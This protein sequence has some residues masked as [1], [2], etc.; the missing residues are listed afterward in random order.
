MIQ[1][2][3]EGEKEKTF[4]LLHDEHAPTTTLL[5]LIAPYSADNVMEERTNRSE[6]TMMD[7]SDY[8]RMMS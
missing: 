6:N 3:N 5:R 7:T 1:K 4:E 8:Y 2:G